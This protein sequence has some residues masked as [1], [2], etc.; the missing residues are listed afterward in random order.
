MYAHRKAMDDH[1]KLAVLAGGQALA[2]DVTDDRLA[3]RIP[4]APGG[5]GGVPPRLFEGPSRLRACRSTRL[6]YPMLVLDW[7]STTFTT[8]DD[9]DNFVVGMGVDCT[10]TGVAVQHPT[11]ATA[12]DLPP[13]PVL[14][15]REE[16]WACVCGQASCAVAL[17]GLF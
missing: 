14:L 5:L 8:A 3:I 17:P 9:E 12:P 2:A 10:C 6:R 13:Q 16:G 11:D 1:V 4:N 15:V 7:L